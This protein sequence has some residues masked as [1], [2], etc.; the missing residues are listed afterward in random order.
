M[1]RDVKEIQDSNI[2]YDT[3]KQIENKGA[4]KNTNLTL[5]KDSVDKSQTIIILGERSTGKSPINLGKSSLVKVLKN[6]FDL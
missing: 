4:K 6:D 3:K 5:I 1:I 2:W